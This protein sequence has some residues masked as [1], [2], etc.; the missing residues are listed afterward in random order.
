MFKF[1]R[2]TSWDARHSGRSVAE[3]RNPEG[4]K[5]PMDSRFHGND[6]KNLNIELN[7]C[8][9]FLAGRKTMD[10]ETGKYPYSAVSSRIDPDWFCF[11]FLKL[12]DDGFVICEKLPVKLLITVRGM[13]MI[14]VFDL[15]NFQ[16]AAFL[17]FDFSRTAALDSAFV[18]PFIGLPFNAMVHRTLGRNLTPFN[19]LRQSHHVGFFVS[20]EYRNCGLKGVWNL[21]ELM[22]AVALEL[23]FVLGH[24]LFTIKPTADK[25]AYYRKKYG[26][27]VL[28]TD[29]K[30]KI[31]GIDIES[32][33]QFMKHVE[34]VTD[35]DRITDICVKCGRDLN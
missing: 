13:C 23:A 21:D 16:H 35:E 19:D 26:A 18:S 5:N 6:E 17:D 32:G 33:R 15:E 12:L 10:D 7:V 8:E 27:K 22:M 24:R 11:D 30:D 2:R 20:P 1:F 34:Y 25:L 4:P 28:M 31:I 29:E 9:S 14:D 3:T